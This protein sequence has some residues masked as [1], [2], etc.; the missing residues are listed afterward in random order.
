MEQHPHQGGEHQQ[1]RL[2]HAHADRLTDEQLIHYGITE[3]L[4]E[5]RAI[6]HATARCIA[7]QLHGGQASPLNALA[8]SG[9]LVEGLQDELDGWRREDTPVE[10]EPWLDALDEY[11][12]SRDD[13][14]PVD[15]WSQLWSSGP[16]REDDEPETGDEER[17][18]YGGSLAC[19]IGRRAVSAR[20]DTGQAEE[21]EAAAR[22]ALFERI[23]AAGVTTLGQI[24]TVHTAG[25]D[26]ESDVF[27]WTDA[28]TWSPSAVA[29]NNYEEP[30]YPP[31]ELDDLFGEGPNEEI[32]SVDELGWYGLVKH[33]D[34]PG[35]LILIQDEQGFRH[36]RE[37]PDD[38]ALT[39][40]WAA[41][42]Q[43]YAT[44]YEQ[45]DA[46]DAA[47][48]EPTSTP[49]GYNPR[50]WVGSLAN[51]NNG[52]LYG[53]W[54]DATLEPDELHAAAQLMLRTSD[55]PSAEEWS[56]M[57]HD[58]FGGYEVSEWSSFDTVSLIARGIAEHG[59][60]YAAW[61]NYVGDTSGELLEPERF[62]DHY[63]GE[64]DSLSDYVEDVLQEMGFYGNLDEALARIPEDLRHYVKVDVEGIAEEWEQGLH[65]VEG[66]NSK[67]F[68]FDARG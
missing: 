9:A 12:D 11:L 68:V 37:A 7:A 56:I 52:Q 61:V 54:M 23:S 57:D 41:I 64:W 48:A 47:T 39:I 6:D 16:G 28:A 10:L 31:D 67:V 8:S 18:P 14:S 27:P 45:R 19:A 60:A 17:P 35:G 25:E 33:E 29:R 59:A 42:Q 62:R 34:R 50:I 51:Y 30:R 43:E 4:R 55:T 21:D 36:V 63:L 44:F 58:D 66:N 49:S 3:A 24:A 20:V 15:G 38:E 22:Q 46:Y 32:G 53:A 40:Q 2:P 1:D 26:D 5:Q 13:P 65:V